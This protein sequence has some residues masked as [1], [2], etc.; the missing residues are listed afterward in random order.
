MKTWL[1]NEKGSLSIEF[2][3]LV[4]FL[5]L[6]FLLLWQVVISGHTIYLAQTAVNEAAKVYSVTEDRTQAENVIREFTN[7]SD[8]IRYTNFAITSDA[9]NYFEVSIT[10]QHRLVF[11]PSSVGELPLAH[12]TFGRVIR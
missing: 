1:K 11:V 3:G 9:N 4:P 7:S 12:G 10:A 8:A 2:L 5:F 6:F